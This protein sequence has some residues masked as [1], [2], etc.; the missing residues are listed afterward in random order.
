MEFTKPDKAV[1]KSIKNT[2][3]KDE[4]LSDKFTSPRPK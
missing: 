4:K 2:A 3:T 1:R